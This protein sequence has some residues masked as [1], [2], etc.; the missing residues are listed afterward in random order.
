MVASGRKSIKYHKASSC[1]PFIWLVHRRGYENN[2]SKKTILLR[3]PIYHLNWKNS[4]LDESLKNDK[5]LFKVGLIICSYGSQ[6]ATTGL[7][8]ANK[9]R[10]SFPPGEE[11][12]IFAILQVPKTNGSKIV[13][14]RMFETLYSG[15]QTTLKSIQRPSTGSVPGQ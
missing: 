2:H 7:S 1:T 9:A 5:I 10:G 14:E 4:K 11:A 13:L 8:G 15:S 6:M 12:E 3:L